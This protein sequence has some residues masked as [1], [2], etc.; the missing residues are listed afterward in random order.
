MTCLLNWRI[1][2]PHPYRYFR[3]VAKYIKKV[4]YPCNRR[5]RPI[6][7]WDVKTPTFS[8][9]SAHRSRWNCR[10]KRRPP[11]TP[12]ERFLVLISVRCWL[13]LKV[14]VRLEGVGKLKN[15]QWLYQDTKPRCF[16]YP[17][18]Y[19]LQKNNTRMKTKR[20]FSFSVCLKLILILNVFTF[21]FMQFALHLKTV[22]DSGPVY[23]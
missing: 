6:R 13:D 21:I 20:L 9:Q 22:Q 5:W 18:A 8:R 10:L 23:A 1:P 12:P 14:L 4:N 7:F 16:N 2:N 15:I 11:F 17:I 3:H 19:S